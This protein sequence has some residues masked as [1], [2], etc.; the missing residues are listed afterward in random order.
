MIM[1]EPLSAEP[2][3]LHGPVVAAQE[4]RHVAFAHWRA[5][6]DVVAPLLPA[7][8]VPDLFDGSA[9]VG[10]IAFRLGE[11][12]LG[13][14]ATPRRLG[15]FTEVNV[16]LYG[17]DAQGRRGVVFRS[18]EA[19]SLPAVLAARAAFSLPYMWARTDQR[20][21]PEGWEYV[22]RRWSASG[23]GPGFRLAVAVDTTTA[24][25]ELSLFLTA[26][27]GLF[28]RR[29]GRTLWLPNTHEPWLLHPA[30]VLSLRDEL[31]P[32]AG[33]PPVAGTPAESV[34]YSPG[35]DARFGRAETLDVR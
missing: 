12:R 9:W 7:G 15:T 27:W 24:D 22:S 6:A 13:L 33:L 30:R 1:P 18:L 35:V 23:D 2:P 19:A 32:A 28:Q 14:F 3:P 25:D 16:R 17:V 10:L 31:V 20:S 11:A 4:W 26:R 21:R 29:F 34:L 5:P 8:V